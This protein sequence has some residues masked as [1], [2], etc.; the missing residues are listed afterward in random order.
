[1]LRRRAGDAAANAN[2]AITF[3]TPD[4]EV[5]E[6]FAELSGINVTRG[7][8]LLLSGDDGRVAIDC[9]VASFN[10]RNGIAQARTIVFDTEN[11]LIHCEGSVRLR[12]ETLDLQVQGEP[13]E[14]RLIRV[15][16]PISNE[17]RWRSP[18]IGVEADD[19][20]GQEGVAA[21]LAALVAPIAGLL[22][23]VDLGLAEDANCAALLADRN[24]T[25]REG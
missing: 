22:P 12:N 23:F 18:E 2:G 14:P 6:A 1:M 24:T 25:R 10:V 5:R 4:G 21:V 15:A 16:A 8:G 7:L 13:N 20:A 19:A 3:V 17:G 9:G 11:V